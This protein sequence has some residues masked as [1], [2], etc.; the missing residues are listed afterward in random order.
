MLTNRQRKLVETLL[1]SPGF[2]RTVQKVHKQIHEFQHGKPPE[3]Y[4]GTNLEEPAQQSGGVKNFMKLFVEE[5]KAGHK[6]DPKNK[7]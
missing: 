4:G 7:K 1:R 2:H 6:P 5:L 3:Y